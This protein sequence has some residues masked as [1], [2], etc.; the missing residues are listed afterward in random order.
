MISACSKHLKVQGDHGCWPRKHV[1]SGFQVAEVCDRPWIR[2]SLLESWSRKCYLN[3]AQEPPG[4]MWILYR[5][6]CTWDPVSQS[7]N[8][9]TQGFAHCSVRSCR[10]SCRFRWAVAF[11]SAPPIPWRR[12][13]QGHRSAWDWEELYHLGSHQWVCTIISGT[14]SLGQP[15]INHGI[16]K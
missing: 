15:V 10:I 14:F 13:P 9:T 2:K 11:P 1:Y 5:S 16:L 6:F 7:V 4:L 8:W 3:N 12:V